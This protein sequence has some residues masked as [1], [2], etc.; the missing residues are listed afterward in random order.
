MEVTIHQGGWESHP[1][2]EGAQVV[3]PKLPC[4]TRNA[5]TVTLRSERGEWKRAIVRWYLASRL[6]NFS[7][8]PLNL[9]FKSLF[10]ASSS[11]P[12]P[13]GKNTNW[14]EPILPDKGHRE[15]SLA[16]LY[17]SSNSVGGR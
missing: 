11:L 9:A 12:I 3:R 16:K 1:K 7:Y 8:P 2:G 5:E 6:L 4:C 10:P 17:A 15:V 13:L 14:S